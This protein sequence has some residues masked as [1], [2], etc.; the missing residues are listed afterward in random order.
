MYSISINKQICLQVFVLQD[1]ILALQAMSEF[2]QLG[3]LAS[4]TDI[5]NINMNVSLTATNFSH[6][7]SINPKNA[8]VLQ[9]YKVGYIQ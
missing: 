9:T 7:V 5:R 3:F 2:A 6:L 8:L 4:Q 1:T